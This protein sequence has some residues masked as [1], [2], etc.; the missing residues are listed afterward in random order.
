MYLNKL[1]IES[2]KALCNILIGVSSIFWFLMLLFFIYS[3]TTVPEY[4]IMALIAGGICVVFLGGIASILTFPPIILKGRMYR[5]EKYNRIFEEDYDGMVPYSAL[6]KL[7]GFTGSKVRN[8][9]RVLVKRNILRNVTF[10]WQGAMVIMKPE[11]QGDFIHVDCPNCGAPIPMRTGG[12]ARCEHCGTY[13]RS[14]SE[15]VH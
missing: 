6:E 2:T 9:I 1:K 15:Y 12:G 5:A 3:F 7:T 8:D 10:G 4:G 11:T 14:E 13:L